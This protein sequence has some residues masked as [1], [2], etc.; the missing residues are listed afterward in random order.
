M[1]SLCSETEA[2]AAVRWA[3][4]DA[5]ATQA[6]VSRYRAAVL[7]ALKEARERGAECES[8][9]EVVLEESEAVDPTPE[10]E[11]DAGGADAGGAHFLP[12]CLRRLTHARRA[13]RG[14]R[15]RAGPA[16]MAGA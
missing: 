13:G 10:E 15:G 1:G 7:A 12:A 2:A 3:A 4:L 14:R 6:E 8:D 5:P 9:E 11:E 16:R